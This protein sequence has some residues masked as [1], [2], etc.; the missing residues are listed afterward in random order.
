MTASPLMIPPT[1]PLNGVSETFLMSSN[2]QAWIPPKWLHQHNKDVLRAEGL[3]NP[4]LCNNNNCHSN[5]NNNNN[6]NNSNNP[7]ILLLLR[8]APALLQRGSTYNKCNGVHKPHRHKNMSINNNSNNNNNNNHSN[9][10]CSSSSNILLHQLCL[11]CRN[12][13]WNVCSISSSNV[14]SSNNNR[15]N[16]NHHS[17]APINNNNNIHKSSAGNNNT[18]LT[19]SSLL[20][21]HCLHRWRP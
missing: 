14:N 5:S 13:N 20:M 1:P 21:R 7:R 19:T 16:N 6:N 17:S 15:N 9:S 8:Y 10:V 18:S 11:I 3:A 2:R 4:H 12:G